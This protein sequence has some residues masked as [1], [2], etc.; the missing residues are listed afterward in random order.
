MMNISTRGRYAAR[1][2]V[3]LASDTDRSSINKFQIAEAEGISPAYVQQL[4]MAL[5]TSGLVVSH[6]GRGGGFSLA[7]APEAITVGEVLRAVEGQVMPAPCRAPGHC[8]RAPTCAVRPL[9]EEAA[10]LLDQLFTGTTIADL[11]LNDPDKHL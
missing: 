2:M 1:I 5:R 10:D 4:L 9:W 11:L 3:M 7:R 8:E 6:R